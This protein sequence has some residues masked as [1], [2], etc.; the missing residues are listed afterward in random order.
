M[1]VYMYLMV[2][3][4]KERRGTIITS[5]KSGQISALAWVNLLLDLRV[6]RNN[7]MEFHPC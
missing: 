6:H 5:S 3:Y 1:E 7:W 4:N 2:R